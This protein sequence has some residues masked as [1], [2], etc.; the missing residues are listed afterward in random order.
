MSGASSF[1]AARVKGRAG[2][3]EVSFAGDRGKRQKVETSGNLLSSETSGGQHGVT[4]YADGPHRQGGGADRLPRLQLNAWEAVA[5]M[6]TTRLNF[7]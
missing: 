1:P 2:E 7:S 3:E 4:V 5:P 6:A